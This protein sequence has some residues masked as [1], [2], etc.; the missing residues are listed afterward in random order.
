LK[1]HT[2]KDIQ[3]IINL[4]EGG[5]FERKDIK[6]LFIDLRPF[7]QEGDRIREIAH[8][9]AHPDSRDRGITFDYL[10]K[11]VND[12]INAAQKGGRFTVK[13]IFSQKDTIDDLI[14]D[15][16]SLGFSVNKILF[17][18]QS[19]NIMRCISEIIDDTPVKLKNNHI[20]DAKIVGFYEEEKKVSLTF[21]FHVTNLQGEY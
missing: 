7:L 2:Q 10:Q 11:F 18:N 1:S 21:I 4:I 3:S 20:L 15:L 13:P 5:I 16:I 12:F 9:I 8:F 14:K 17:I 6:A 19:A